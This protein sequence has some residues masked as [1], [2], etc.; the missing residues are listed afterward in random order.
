[1]RSALITTAMLLTAMLAFAT[2]IEEPSAVIELESNAID[3]AG[4]TPLDNPLFISTPFVAVAVQTLEGMFIYAATC[5][6]AV[7]MGIDAVRAS[8]LVNDPEVKGKLA[9]LDGMVN[10]F[11]TDSQ[12]IWKR[13]P[14]TSVEKSTMNYVE[15]RAD[16]MAQMMT[17]PLIN[18][19]QL[20]QTC[21][22]GF[23]IYLFH[24]G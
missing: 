22:M 8:D 16:L 20:A 19:Q 24:E 12:D 10:T 2:T 7:Q 13:L 6:M 18:R 4:G 5:G 1:M 17:Y 3:P 9:V 23:E 15:A 21:I 11:D 14:D